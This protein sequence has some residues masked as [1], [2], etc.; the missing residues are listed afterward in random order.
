MSEHT[1]KQHNKTLLLYHIVCPAK[2]R[3]K[4]FTEAVENTLKEVCMGIAERHEIHF[5]ES[6]DPGGDRGGPQSERGRGLESRP[7]HHGHDGRKEPSIYFLAGAQLNG[8]ADPDRR[9]PLLRDESNLGSSLS[10]PDEDDPAVVGATGRKKE[11]RPG[12]I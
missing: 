8:D 6:G 3:R 12:V 1:F 9:R 11:Q 2:Y 5:V 10:T 7:R 4:V